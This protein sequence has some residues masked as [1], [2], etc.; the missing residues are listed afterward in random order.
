MLG[1]GRMFSPVLALAHL[2]LR[3]SIM[4]VRSFRPNMSRGRCNHQVI[5]W[6]DHLCATLLARLILEMTS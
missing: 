4:Q 6:L 2:F 1:R 3:M 5:V